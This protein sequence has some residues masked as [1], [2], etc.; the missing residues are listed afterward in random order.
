MNLICDDLLLM[1]CEKLDECYYTDC[2]ITVRDLA[3]GK[4]MPPAYPGSMVRRHLLG[5]GD[6]VNRFTPVLD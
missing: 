3:D 1:V 6:V 4:R 2:A 5:D